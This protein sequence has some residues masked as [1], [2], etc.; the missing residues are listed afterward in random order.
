MRPLFKC[1]ED[2][3]RSPLLAMP[4]VPLLVTMPVFCRLMGTVLQGNI[5][6]LHVLPYNYPVFAALVDQLQQMPPNIK[7]APPPAWRQELDRLNMNVAIICFT[8]L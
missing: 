6:C 3:E 1:W 7:I 4:G 2:D 5:V 8:S